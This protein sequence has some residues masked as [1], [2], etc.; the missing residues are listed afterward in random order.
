MLIDLFV[1]YLTG[2]FNNQRQIEEE[3][4][5][6]PRAVHINRECTHRIAGL[7]SDCKDRFILEESYYTKA[8]G[9]QLSAPHLFGVRLNSNNCVEL[10]AY[11]MPKHLTEKDFVNSNE[12][13][14]LT[15]EGLKLSDNFGVMQYSYDTHTGFV[16]ELRNEYPNGITFTLTEVISQNRLEVMELMEKNGARLTS[17][18]TPIIY[19]KIGG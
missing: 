14:G 16:G 11:K 5:G 3:H 17:Y 6:H 19:E 7:P 12:H 15:F 4:G 13:L 9:T 18:S 8:D 10:R 2:D 1:E